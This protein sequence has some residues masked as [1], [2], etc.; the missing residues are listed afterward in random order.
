M[1]ILSCLIGFNIQLPAWCTVFPLFWGE[2]DLSLE[3]HKLVISIINVKIVLTL[4]NLY[5]LDLEVF[6][7]LLT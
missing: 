3:T 6:V 4:W 5:M 2:G 7:V 1:L